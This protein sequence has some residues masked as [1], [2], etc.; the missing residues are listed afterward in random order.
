MLLD[1]V[2]CCRLWG[3]IFE[4]ASAVKDFDAASITAFLWA[5][6]A[7]GQ[8]VESRRLFWDQGCKYTHTDTQTAASASVGAKHP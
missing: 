2:G 3:K 4:R 5:A 6:T 1:C 8:C 7:A